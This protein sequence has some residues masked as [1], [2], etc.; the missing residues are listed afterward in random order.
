[1][2]VA[3]TPAF[4]VLDKPEG[5]AIN[6]EGDSLGFISEFKAALGVAAHPVH[7]LDKD[8]SGLLLVAK[9]AESNRVLSHA[10]QLQQVEKRYI[11][12]V[13]SKGGAKPKKKQG[14]IKGD[15]EKSRNG[16]WKLCGRN[17]NPAITYF[18]S[19]SLGERRRLCV[20]QPKTGKTHQLRVAMKSLSMPIVGDTRYGGETSD[21]MYLHAAGLCFEYEGQEHRYC[22]APR[23]G[24]LFSADS[25]GGISELIGWNG[26]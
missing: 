10:F 1:M 7:R 2:I 16:S 20:L 12:V 18:D 22:L 4:W 25:L 6:D 19:F 24:A 26:Q 8:T 5:I 13:S 15:M 17:N 3:E 9:H 23:S 21:R 11:A 14:W